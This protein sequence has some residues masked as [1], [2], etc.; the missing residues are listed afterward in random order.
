MTV[1]VI[2]AGLAGVEAAQAITS[3]GIPVTLYEIKPHKYT[4]AHSYSGLRS[5]CA[6]IL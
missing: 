6:A 2:G 1:T 4:P 3:Y 5:W